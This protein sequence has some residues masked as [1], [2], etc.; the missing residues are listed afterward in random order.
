MLYDAYNTRQNYTDKDLDKI[1]KNCFS[2]FKNH[3]LDVQKNHLTNLKLLICMNCIRKEAQIVCLH[4]N[5]VHI[6]DWKIHCHDY[7]ILEDPEKVLWRPIL[8][9]FKSKIGTIDL[10]DYKNFLE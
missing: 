3:L 9:G 6:I 8:N 1:L 7:L 4:Q 2:I 5:S 10:F